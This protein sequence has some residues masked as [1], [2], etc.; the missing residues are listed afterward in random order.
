MQLRSVDLNLLVVLDAVLAEGS[1]QGAAKRLALSP[2]ATSHAMARLR[3][4]FGDPL[5]VRAGRQMVPT[6]RAEALRGPLREV[7]QRTEGLFRPPGAVEPSTVQRALRVV[8]TDYVELVLMPSLSARFAREAPGIDLHTS[9]GRDDFARW[10]RDGRAD[11]AIGV[12]YDA[13]APGLADLA[14]EELFSERFV[15]VVR[16]DHPVVEAGLDLEAYTALHHVLVSPG[17]GTTGIVDQLLEARGLGRRVARTT[18]SFL[19][20]PRLVTGTDYVLTLSERL[21]RSLAPALGLAILAPPIEL[22]SFTISLVW[23]ERWSADPVHRWLRGQVRDLS[24]QA[25]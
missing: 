19:A 20:A 4:Q 18:P 10:L 25:R 16:A 8:T 3:E 24:A 9:R 2:S 22:P 5:L 15:C 12:F 17:G 1:V 11:L 7:L 13:A 14:R 23:H 6:A 21:A